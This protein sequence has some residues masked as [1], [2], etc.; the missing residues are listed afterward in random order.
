M[1]KTE[2]TVHVVILAGGS[3]TRFW[4]VSRMERPKQFLSISETG[5]SLIQATARRNMPL[6]GGNAPVW[7]V[8]NGLQ[9]V[10][11]REHVPTARILTEPFGKNTA[12]SIGLAAAH[13]CKEDPN[14]IMVV[15]AADHAVQNEA[16]YQK[17]LEEAVRLAQVT[18]NL[19]TI[20]IKPASPNTAYG[21]IKKGEHIQD[22]GFK[23][24]RFFEKPSLER[25]MQY[26]DS[27]DFF[28]NS[29]MFA[30]KTSVLRSLNE[31]APQLFSGLSEYTEFIGTE[32]EKKELKK[33]FEKIESISIDFA[34]LE[35]AKNCAVVCSDDFG[36]NDVGSWDAWA[37]HY[38]KDEK[39]NLVKGDVMIFDSEN[40]IIRS[41]NRFVALVG[42]ENLVVIECKDATLVCARDQV[43]DV[44]KI[45]A[46]LQANG[47]FELI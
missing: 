20:G 15:L 23:V 9:E 12:A 33:F 5:E 31:Y 11:T 44:K 3:G 41:D 7:I 13:I 2:G 45:V 32:N 29:G 26:F 34:V 14:S 27:P 30:W 8:T 10:I 16:V 47:R 28:W 24:N 40:C 42:C 38:S 46:A 18:D 21:Y 17:T 39:G 36:W 25:A 35:H 19:I 4:P 22:N 37:E 6:G 1:G 43:Q